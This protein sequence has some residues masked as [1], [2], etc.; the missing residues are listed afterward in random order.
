MLV[1]CKSRFNDLW[2]EA[3]VVKLICSTAQPRGS[4]EKRWTCVL[5]LIESRHYLLRDCYVIHKTLI[6]NFDQRILK[7]DSGAWVGNS[8]NKQSQGA[9]SFPL[10]RSRPPRFKASFSLHLPPKILQIL[11][12]LG[13]ISPWRHVHGSAAENKASGEGAP[14]LILSFFRPSTL[15]WSGPP[16]PRRPTFKINMAASAAKPRSSAESLLP[17]PGRWLAAFSSV[18]PRMV[19]S[20][21]S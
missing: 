20:P 16:A 13:G 17:S 1:I 6:L 4:C 8:L 11:A 18:A 9:S 2:Q 19:S 21:R 3:L 14:P 12:V 7:I 10:I 15:A 5:A